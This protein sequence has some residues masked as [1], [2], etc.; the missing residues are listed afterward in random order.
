MWH[1]RT[2][3]LHPRPRHPAPRPVLVHR[4]GREVG[5]AVVARRAA[6]R[7]RQPRRRRVR[8]AAARRRRRVRRSAA[9]LFRIALHVANDRVRARRLALLTSRAL[10]NVWSERP[11][12]LGILA[13]LVLVFIV[14]FPDALD[15]AP[16][17]DRA[18]GRDVAV[19]ERARHV[20]DRLRLP[21]AASD[22]ARARGPSAERRDASATLLRGTL[23][24]RAW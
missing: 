24:R 14:E 15:R 23:D 6:L 12:M 18:A 11:L 13:M 17:A 4:A 20:R 10:L 8:A 5:R 3:R 2:G 1:L 16:P 7:R 19:G 21:R 9:T 22:R